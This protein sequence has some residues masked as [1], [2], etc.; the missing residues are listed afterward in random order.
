M[1]KMKLNVKKGTH[2]NFEKF[3]AELSAKKGKVQ[4]QDETVEWLLK[5]R[6]N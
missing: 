4:S 3:R 6:K 1:D 2:E 5:N